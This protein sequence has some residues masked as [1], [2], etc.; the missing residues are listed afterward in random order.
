MTVTT[1]GSLYR[2]TDAFVEELVRSG[3][4]HACVCPGSRSTPLAVLLKRNSRL[5]VWTHLDERSSTYFA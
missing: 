5:R 3:V 2:S 4:H 1:G